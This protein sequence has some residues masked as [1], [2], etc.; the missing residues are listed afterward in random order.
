MW[1][2]FLNDLSAACDSIGI[3]PFPIPYPTTASPLQWSLPPPTPLIFGLSPS[4]V[5]REQYWPESVELCGFWKLPASWLP[6]KHLDDHVQSFIDSHRGRLV[7]TGFGSM[8]RY[9]TDTDWTKLMGIFDE[10]MCTCILCTL[11][12]SSCL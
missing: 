3:C 8:E 1:R 7:Y 12:T 2:L 4:L 9:M 11:L 10:G 5:P 6:V